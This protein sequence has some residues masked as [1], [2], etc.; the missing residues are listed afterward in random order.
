MRQEDSIQNSTKKDDTFEDG[1]HL[2]VKQP[3]V[4]SEESDDM[5]EISKPNIKVSPIPQD[6]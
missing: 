2:T 3:N 5:D 4:R 1:A 6:A